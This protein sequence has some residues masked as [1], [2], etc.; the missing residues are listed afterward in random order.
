MIKS[1]ITAFLPALKFFGR[2]TPK[3]QP[4]VP[5]PDRAKRGSKPKK[6]TETRKR[7]KP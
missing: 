5:S 3:A 1:I 7:K 6:S 2:G 4:E